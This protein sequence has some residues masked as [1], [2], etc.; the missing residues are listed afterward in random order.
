MIT[1]VFAAAAL[2]S[3]ALAALRPV[4]TRA[5]DAINPADFSK[6]VTNPYLPLSSIRSL[7]F[8][9]EEEDPDTGETLETRSEWTILADQKTVAGVSVLVVRDQAFADG[10]LVESTLDYYAQHT[11]GTVYY[12]GEDVDNYEDGVIVD[13]EGSW[14]AGEGENEPG[15]FMP[16]SPSA[17][18]EFDQER[19]PGIAEDHSTVQEVGLT[20]TVPAGTFSNCIKTE[21]EDPLAP[22]GATENKWYCSGVGLVREE[23]EDEFSELVSITRAPAAS[24][25]AP[26]PTAA[27]PVTTPPAGVIS[28]PATGAGE[29]DHAVEKTAWLL[30]LVLVGA[31]GTAA[32][33]YGLVNRRRG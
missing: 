13:H 1:K 10:E 9:G 33:V 17:G 8:E 14:L 11:D 5:Q 28:A 2:L 31:A 26:A 30:P 12:F 25:T 22:G 7:V 4:E 3:L 27:G 24:P 23:A 6:N 18:D 29:H 19:A 20:I 16:A 32:T 15:I 21:D